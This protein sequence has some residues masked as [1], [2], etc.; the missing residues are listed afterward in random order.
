MISLI[1]RQIAH[2]RRGESGQALLVVV[3]TIGTILSLLLATVYV[4]H[5]GGEKV[6]AANSVDAIALSA[7]TWEA[8]GLNLIAALNDGILQCMS[9]IRSICVVWAAL[10][11]AACTGYGA[12]AFAAYSKYARRVIKSYWRCARQLS[13]WS[14]KVKSLTPY[15][16]L[17]DTAALAKKLNVAGLLSPANPGGGHDAENTLE[18]H[19]KEGPPVTVLDAMGPIVEFR[20]RL[21]S[22]RFADT[23]ASLIDSVIRSIV[24]ADG[25]PIRLL[26]PEDDF[27]RRQHVRFSGLATV[28]PLPIPALDWIRKERLSESSSAEP[29]GGE[30]AK[31][32]WKSRLVGTE[33]S[34]ENQS[35]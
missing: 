26:E 33:D 25:E 18:L 20:N 11:A 6:T 34:H 19:L 23:I 9:V 1:P 3:V 15:L 35:E 24:G 8:R 30:T 7:A 17:E 2:A 27:E 28:S 4:N 13:E 31:M 22:G 16:A 12:P 29:Y 21:G 5:L 32:T 14:K 10:A